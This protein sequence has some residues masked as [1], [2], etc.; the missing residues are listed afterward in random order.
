MTREKQEILKKL[1]EL[2]NE[3]AAE[4]EMA[5]GFGSDLIDDTFERIRM[6]LL[7]RLSM[8]RHYHSV[9]DMMYDFRGCM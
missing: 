5:C 8:L 4:Y 9:N 7:E 6:P 3:E 2:D 1:N